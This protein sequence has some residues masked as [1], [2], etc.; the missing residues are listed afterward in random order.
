M[1]KT[2]R[3]VVFMKTKCVII[4]QYHLNAFA[5]LITPA[6]TILIMFQY[7]ILFK[8]KLITN[9]ARTAPSLHEKKLAIV[10][11]DDFISDIF[12]GVN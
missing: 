12:L 5:S 7:G 11:Q 10:P 9:A 3:E 1:G 8:M 2:A 4:D 6:C